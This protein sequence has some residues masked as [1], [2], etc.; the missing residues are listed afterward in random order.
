MPHALYIFG[1]VN[2]SGLGALG[3]NT[4]SFII[5]IITF[6]I[7]FLVLKKFAFKPILKVMKERRELIESGVKLGEE[8]KKKNVE[9]ESEIAE[10]LSK[11]RADADNIISSAQQDAREVIVTAEE[12]AKQKVEQVTAD[13][14]DRIKRDTASARKQLE[15]E[16]VGLI[17]EATEAIIDE[18]IDAKKDASLIDRALKQRNAS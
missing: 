5:Q 7:V 16:L 14:Q 2:A 9:L 12:N 6:V 1:D 13:A 17:S 10:K 11:A 15:A 18:K 8:M 4:Q 3:V